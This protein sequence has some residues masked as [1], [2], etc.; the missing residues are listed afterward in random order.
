VLIKVD[1][2]QIELRVA[3]RIAGEERMIEAYRRKEDLHTLTAR[4]LTSRQEVTKQERQLAKPVNFGLIYGLGP[5]SLRKKAATEYGVVMSMEQAQEYRQ[6]FFRAWPGIRRWHDRLKR[7]R[8]A[9]TRTL[10]GRR[11]IIPVDTWHGKRANYVVQ[12]TAGDGIKASLALL[13][14][15]RSQAVG[16]SPIAIVHDELVLEANVDQAEA[17]A[18]WVKQ[19]MLDGMAPLIAPV[20]VDVEVTIAPTWGG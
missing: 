14:E 16:A 11:V 7:E 8:T 10:L 13:W 9:E 18:A 12:G 15:R 4:Q 3:A 19:A 1:F 2:S 6:A 20:P 17:V 5:E